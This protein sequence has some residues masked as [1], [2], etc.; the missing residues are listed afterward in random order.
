[1]GKNRGRG[2]GY[3]SSS[4][5]NN[6]CYNCGSADHWASD[7]TC[8]RKTDTKKRK[9]IQWLE[10]ELASGENINPPKGNPKTQNVYKLQAYEIYKQN[11]TIE[12]VKKHLMGEGSIEKRETLKKTFLE[13][14]VAQAQ[15]R[16]ERIMDASAWLRDQIAKSA[17]LVAPSS[18]TH[19]FGTRGALV[20]IY[21]EKGWPGVLNWE[22]NQ[23]KS[24]D[25]KQKVQIQKFNKEQDEMLVEMRK[26]QGDVAGPS[27]VQ[28]DDEDEGEDKFDLDEMVDPDEG[29][30]I[31]E[32][33]HSDAGVPYQSDAGAPYQPEEG[34]I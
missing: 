32:N 3:G 8:P 28:D 19:N 15:A 25:K 24:N 22:R 7:P 33:D 5:R 30:N 23:K 10:K 13:N 11:G 20:K 27:G 34:T 14:K 9:A 17:P 6:N 12:A 29:V 18:N 1:M 2:I 21:N 26:L 4:Y 31:V 16:Y